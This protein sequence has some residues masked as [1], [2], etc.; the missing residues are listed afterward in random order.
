MVFT[1]GEGPGLTLWCLVDFD[2]RGLRARYSRV[3]PAMRSDVV[4]VLC[5]PDGDQAAWID[6]RYTL[7][8]LSD[9]GRRS[10]ADFE[11]AAFA[12]RIEGWRDLIE[13]R[14]PRLL[15]WCRADLTA[16]P[17]ESPSRS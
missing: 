17:A 12:A 14:L 9:E 5:Q 1:T 7:T 8:A 16:V 3:T 6:V 15:A 2:E 11:A 4:E 10:F 13:A